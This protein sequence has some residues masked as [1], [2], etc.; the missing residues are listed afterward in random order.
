MS[1]NCKL[2]AP[3][4]ESVIFFSALGKAKETITCSGIP[5]MCGQYSAD[6]ITE[7]FLNESP[8]YLL[9]VKYILEEFNSEF[10]FRI[11]EGICFSPRK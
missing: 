6:I 10:S 1:F 9:E 3:D 7:W 11:R 8:S 4:F 5:I 2:N